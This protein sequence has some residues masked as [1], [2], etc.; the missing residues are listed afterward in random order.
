MAV[1]RACGRVYHLKRLFRRLNG[2]YF[3]GQIRARVEWGRAGSQRRVASREFGSYIFEDRL[4]RI[5]PVLDQAWIPPYVVES[6]LF[7]EMCHQFCPEKKLA[8]RVLTHTPEFRHKEREYAQF[9][10]AEAWLNQHLKRL[11]EPTARVRQVQ[12]TQPT[13]RQLLFGLR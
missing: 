6:V 9:A 3:Q 5:H 12:K 13:A 4:I 8:G 10:E 11:L 1:D 2:L 7:H